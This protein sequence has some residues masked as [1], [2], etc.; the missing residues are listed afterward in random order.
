MLP[1]NQGDAGFALP[2]YL[3]N[4]LLVQ[5]VYLAKKALRNKLAAFQT[6]FP[7]GLLY[8]HKLRKARHFQD[9]V[10]F[11]G[12]LYHG[13]LLMFLNFFLLDHLHDNPQSCRRNKRQLLRIKDY[14]LMLLCRPFFGNITPHFSGIDRIYFSFQGND[15]C[16][17][18]HGKPPLTPAFLS[19]FY[20][21]PNNSCHSL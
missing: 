19:K 20:F 21:S 8:L 7:I 12:N 17:I 1:L 9:I 16:K 13:N 14:R 11:L 4:R 3:D 6:D 5:P 18:I 2:I 10:H 15:Q